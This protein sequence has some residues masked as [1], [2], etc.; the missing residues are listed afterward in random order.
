LAQIKGGIEQ[1]A[2]QL[3]TRQHAR[4][5]VAPISSSRDGHILGERNAIMHHAHSIQGEPK[6]SEK[7]GEKFEQ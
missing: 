3:V 7:F 6:R 5:A 1:E 2:E 4:L